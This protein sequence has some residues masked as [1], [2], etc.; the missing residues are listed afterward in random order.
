MAVSRLVELAG[1]PAVIGL[2]QDL[3][4]GQAFEPAFER[5]ALVPFHTFVTGL[6]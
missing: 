4:E 2:L 6:R 5:R 1:T 3:A